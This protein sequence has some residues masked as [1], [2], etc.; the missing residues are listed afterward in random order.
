MKKLYIIYIFISLF[1]IPLLRGQD[2]KGVLITGKIVDDTGFEL[3]GA[4]VYEI[5]DQDRIIDGV[6]TDISGNFSYR[7][8]GSNSRL[9]ITYIGFVP[10]TVEINGQTNFEIILKTDI[11]SLDEVTV[12]GRKEEAVDAGYLSINKSEQ[13]TATS[14]INMEEVGEIQAVSAAEALQGRIAGVNIELASADPG[15]GIRIQIRGN[16]SLLGGTSD[17]LIVLD[18]IPLQTSEDFDFSTNNVEDYS[19]L[20]DIPVED[21]KE[22]SILRDAASTAIYGSQAANGVV[23]IKTKRG[24]KGKPRVEYSNRFSITQ[25]PRQ[26]PLLNGNEYATLMLEGLFNENEGLNVAVPEELSF[27]PNFV[28]FQEYNDNTDWIDAITQTGFTQAHNLAVSGGGDKSRYRISTGYTNQQGITIGTDLDRI[29]TALNLDY[30]VSRK[31]RF[32]ADFRYTNTNNR[33]SFD[34]QLRSR[35]YRKAPNMSIFVED[36]N[37]NDTDVYFSPEENFQGD[38]FFWYNPVAMAR[39]AFRRVLS[40]RVRS[41]LSVR[42]KVSPSINITSY[43]VYDVDSKEVEA[44][45][46]QIVVGTVWHSDRTNVSNHNSG[47]SNNFNF[48]TKAVYSKELPF[49]FLP[50]IFQDNGQDA[51]QKISVVGAFD[52]QTRRTLSFSGTGIRTASSDLQSYQAPSPIN[53]FNNRE[54]EFRGLSYTGLVHYSIFSRYLFSASVRA[55]GTSRFGEN[56]RFGV[57]PSAGVGW[58]FSDE[59]FMNGANFLNFAKFRYSYGV[60]GT[61]PSRDVVTTATYARETSYVDLASVKPDGL[62]LLNLKWEESF[63]SNWGLEAVMFDNKVSFEFDYYIKKTFDIIVPNFEIPQLT[64]GRTQAFGNGASINNRGWEFST[65]I[66]VYS[67]NDLDISFNFNIS[68]NRNR[69]IELPDS[70]ESERGN[71][72]ENGQYLK[73]IEVGK[74]NGAFFGYRHLGVFATDDDAILRNDEGGIIFEADGITPRRLRFNNTDGYAFRGGDAIYEDI[75]GDGVIN[76]L[77]IVFLGDANPQFYGGFGTNVKYKGF[78]LKAFL[79]YNLGQDVINRVRINTENMHNRSN[80]SAVVTNRWRKP[81]DVTNIP[82]ALLNE[83]FNWLG[84]DRFVEEASF[85]RVNNITFG[86]QFRKSQLSKLGLQELRTY[87]TVVNPYT[88]TNY[89]GQDPQIGFNRRDPWQY[90]ED[91][92]RTPA[93]IVYTIGLST[94]F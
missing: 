28:N 17:P 2:S 23:I 64:G 41:V 31:L 19:A 44:F 94:K 36:E 51:V 30:D 75:N 69:V 39:E 82:R 10:Q 6:V 67:K 32:S 1:S 76:E 48:R 25:K 78:F 72:L 81:G 74:P 62:Q 20:I 24:Q 47:T 8:K 42:Y 87:V 61:N 29:F 57:F 90:G 37:G 5:N 26:I 58:V 9:R 49:N 50:G 55:D 59:P 80:Q 11:E 60:N 43:G 79:R 22:I 14:T 71:V 34:D 89:T 84:S 13:V 52:L 38:G 88:W 85:L 46:P 63:Q 66:N 16:T 3:P 68:R 65:N 70:W 77:D 12:V 92:A 86:Y 56:Q 40:N 15:A 21:I 73:R 27:D 93:P 4:T 53:G 35:A 45:R 7:L 91:N 83:G 54:N 33:Q 18:D